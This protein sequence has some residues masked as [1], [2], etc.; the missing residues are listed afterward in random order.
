MHN[1]WKMSK[2]I[3]SQTNEDYEYEAQD[4]VCRN[5][6]NKV[7][8]SKMLNYGWVGYTGDQNQIDRIKE[9]L[10]TGPMSIAVSAGNDC[11]RWY[12]GG[13]LSALDN[14]PTSIDHGVALVGVARD[15]QGTEFW[16][17]QNSWGSWWGDR[18][19][20]YL[21]VETGAGVTGMNMYVQHMSTDPDFPQDEDDSSGDDSSPNPVPNCDHNEGNNA[22]G[23]HTCWDDSECA[24]MRECSAWGWCHGRSYCDEP[25]P[26]MCQIDESQ[27][28]R[29]P[30]RCW[31][32][33]ECHGDR[34]CSTWGW[35]QGSSNC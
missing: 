28:S 2:E 25:L 3:G 29:G 14:C 31:N 16:V 6:N 33:V 9:Q 19:Y 12:K 10:Q 17:V 22:W 7:I 24:G 26:D 11:W 21:A 27:N 5:Q 30:N 4:G 1:Y 8:A 35:C 23:P 13:I 34:T 15:A 18:G 32:S 20:I